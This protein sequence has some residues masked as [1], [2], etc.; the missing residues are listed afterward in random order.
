MIRS[1]RKIVRL[2]QERLLALVMLPAFFLAT[3][4]HTACICGDGHREAHCNAAAC[5]AFNHGKTVTS[6]CGCACC[7]TKG[8]GRT[9]CCGKC[10]N[11]PAA[12]PEESQPGVA[13]KTGGCCHPYLEAPSPT[14][15]VKKQV[16]TSQ[17]D[18]VISP[19]SSQTFTVGSSISVVRLPFDYHGPPPRDAVIVFQHL[20]I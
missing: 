13:A 1:I 17:L 11:K 8:D 9:G 3:L 16:F 14:A 10:K 4:P 18:V 5:C 2:H 15:V 7:K 12:P 20:T 6:C 19:V